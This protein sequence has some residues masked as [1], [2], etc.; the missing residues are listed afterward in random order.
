MRVRTT[1]LLFGVLALLAVGAVAAGCGGDDESTT[2]S[3]AEDTATEADSEN[4]E[5]S[6][7]ATTTAEAGGQNLEIKMGEF[8]YK[9]AVVT[10]VAG[11]ATI[12]APNEGNAPHELVLA[13]TNDDPAKLPTTA[14]GS[15]DEETLDIP[16]EVE[17]VESGATG[18][19]TLDLDPG[20]YVMFCNVPGHYKAGMYGALTVE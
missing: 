15:V 1:A 14:D 7:A 2:A 8:Y 19:T 9:P 18:S 17:E 12:E 4:S 6:S 10:A 3:G 20:E 11:A 5:E 16:G 13:K